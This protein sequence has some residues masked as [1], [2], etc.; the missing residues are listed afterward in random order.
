MEV[1]YRCCCGLDVHQASMTACVLWS[2]GGVRKEKRRFGTCT[3]DLLQLAD[4][5]RACGVTHIAMEATGR[6][7]EAGVEHSRRPVC[8]G[9]AGQRAAHQGG[10]RSEDGSEGQRLDCGLTAAWV[11]A[12]ELRDL[13]RSRMSL[14]QECTRI[15]SRIQKVL[16]DANLKLASVA[17]DALGASGR[18]ML[19]AI[20]AGEDDVVTSPSW[21]RSSCGTRFP[22]CARPWRVASLRIIGSCSGNC[23]TISTTRNGR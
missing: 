4:W 22:R 11:V 17:T 21:R 3:S 1:V 20:I 2:E 7:L 13:T 10:A 18:A 12:R 6:V 16:E 14:T 19:R 23:S 15:A 5:L 9:P 8:R